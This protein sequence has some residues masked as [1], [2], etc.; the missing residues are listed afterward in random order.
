MFLIAKRL[1]LFNP[2]SADPKETTRDILVTWKSHRPPKWLPRG[3]SPHSI[4]LA[5]WSRPVSLKWNAVS[6][7]VRT[8]VFLHWSGNSSNP[9]TVYTCMFINMWL[10]SGRKHKNWPLWLGMAAGK[11]SWVIGKHSK[12]LTF[13]LPTYPLTSLWRLYMYYCVFENMFIANE[14]TF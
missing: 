14:L 2:G 13:H 10:I 12:K 3:T 4:H 1:M 9:G 8:E 6:H 5:V 7:P 11:D